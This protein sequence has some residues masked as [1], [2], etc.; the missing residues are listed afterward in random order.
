MG[1]ML[2]GCK[3]GIQIGNWSFHFD[4]RQPMLKSIQLFQLPIQLE[5]ETGMRI[6]LFEFPSL[7]L[8]VGSFWHVSF[9]YL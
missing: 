9:V 1:M 5:L 6:L 7:L 3:L 2:L 4:H 8:W